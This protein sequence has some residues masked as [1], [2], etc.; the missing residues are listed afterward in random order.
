M[1]ETLLPRANQLRYIGGIMAM[2]EKEED[3]VLPSHVSTK[4]IVRDFPE[5][6]KQRWGWRMGLVGSVITEHIYSEGKI[7]QRSNRLFQT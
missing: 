2:P 4:N 3:R 1:V 7:S 5:A 6:I